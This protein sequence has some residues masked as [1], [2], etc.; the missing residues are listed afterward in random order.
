MASL[1]P[2]IANA[3]SPYLRLVRA[4]YWFVVDMDFRHVGYWREQIAICEADFL[5]QGVGGSN[6]PEAVRERR[7]ALIR[8]QVGEA[9]REAYASSQ[10]RFH[11][12]GCDVPQ[13]G[14]FESG[15]V[16]NTRTLSPGGDFEH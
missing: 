4:H 14:L 8:Q 16:C 1:H 2:Y 11:R 3:T 12:G 6:V 9:M 15:S 10:K 13:C 7:K 5:A